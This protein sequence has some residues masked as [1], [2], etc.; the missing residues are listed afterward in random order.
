MSKFGFD[1]V[2]DKIENKKDDLASKLIT[3]SHKYFIKQFKAEQFGEGN[4]WKD[5]KESTLKLKQH[6]K[7]IGD[8]KRADKKLRRT[9]EL[10]NALKDAKLNKSWNDCSLRVDCDY[11]SYHNE[12]DGLDKRQFVGNN[13]ELDKIQLDIINNWIKNM[14]PKG[15]IDEYGLE[16]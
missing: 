1:K 15:S 9:D 2:I 4:K 13:N 10:F 8:I 5:L 6:L 11:A 3:A 14:F 12:G 16:Q 7:A